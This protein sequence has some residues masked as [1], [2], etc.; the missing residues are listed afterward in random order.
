MKFTPTAATLISN[1]PGPGTGRVVSPS[2]RTSGPPARRARIACIIW[3]LLRAG[4]S[5]PFPGTILGT[6]AATMKGPSVT[7]RHVMAGAGSR[8][9]AVW[10][11]AA[12]DGRHR[13]LEVASRGKADVVE[14]ADNN[15]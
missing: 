8:G 14:V 2:S 5:V 3:L 4:N 1:W 13:A 11:V 9:C 7:S 6:P 10:L 12:G 15:A